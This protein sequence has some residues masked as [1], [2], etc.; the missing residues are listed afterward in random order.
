[1][2]QAL[3]FAASITGLGQSLRG[4]RSILLPA[5]FLIAPFGQAQPHTPHSTQRLA[6][7]ACGC[8]GAFAV[9]HSGLQFVQL[10]QPS[11]EE[12]GICR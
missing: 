5:A 1:M 4:M 11:P 12:S 8:F 7:M 10:R 9:G 2:P 3:H 6:L